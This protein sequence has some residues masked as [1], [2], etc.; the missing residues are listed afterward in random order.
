VA[1]DRDLYGELGLPPGA[2]EADIKRAFRQQAKKAHPD[3]GGTPEKFG[4][5]RLAHDVRIDP[6][7]R[8]RYDSTGKF[9]DAPVDNTQSAIVEIVAGALDDAIQ[10]AIKGN[11]DPA[12]VDLKG[13][14]LASLGKGVD[15]MNEELQGI[16]MAMK[17]ARKLAKRWR[18]KRKKDEQGKPNM[19]AMIL[20]ERV[21]T[22]EGAAKQ[23][24]ER[25]RVL[26]LARA[27][28]ADYE[29]DPERPQFATAF[30]TFPSTYP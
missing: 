3:A 18:R 12:G 14:I 28:M 19:L 29:F 8:A 22:L 11:R 15:Q 23:V 21:R 1:A 17:L 20:D 5:L 27:W 30:V 25:L 7:R 9:E 2:S 24:E 10:T 6:D 13:G 16:R 4:A 26:G